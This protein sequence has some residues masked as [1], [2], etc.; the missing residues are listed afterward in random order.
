VL[1]HVTDFERQ[2]KLLGGNIA[3]EKA[4]KAHTIGTKSTKPFKKTG[5]CHNCGEIGHWKRE[6][7][8][9]PK[10]QES[11][12]TNKHRGSTKSTDKSASTG[13]L[14]TPGGNKGLTPAHTANKS[15]ENAWNTIIN[16]ETSGSTLS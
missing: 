3:S 13:P 7:P 15:I 8:K 16:T 2:I 4:L 6:C 9:P 10:D 5:K 14:P 12:G 1:A 11:K